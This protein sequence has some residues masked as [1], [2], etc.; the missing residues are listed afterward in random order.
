M[1]FIVQQDD[2]SAINA[3]AD[4]ARF[5]A[6]GTTLVDLMREHIERPSAL[7]DINRLPHRHI[8][9][10]A[11]GLEIGALARMSDVAA[12]RRVAV[13]YPVIVESLLASASPQIRH[14]ASSDGNLLQRTRCTYFRDPGVAATRSSQGPAVPRGWACTGRTRSSARARHASR[15]MRQTSR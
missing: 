15:R 2:E 12:D 3:A 11:R 6:G 13:T 7:V 9:I 10:T 1:G 4:G 14:M 8:E 5:L